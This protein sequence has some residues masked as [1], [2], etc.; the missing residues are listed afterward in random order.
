MLHDAVAIW[1]PI[2]PLLSFELMLEIY[3]LAC[4]SKPVESPLELVAIFQSCQVLVQTAACRSSPPFK[5][6]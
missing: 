3:R 6:H 1:A 2:Y 4:G 5:R